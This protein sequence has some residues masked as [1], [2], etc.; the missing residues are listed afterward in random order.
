LAVRLPQEVLSDPVLLAA[1]DDGLSYERAAVDAHL[2]RAWCVRRAVSRSSLA[3]ARS[4][5]S[6][7]LP[8]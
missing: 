2:R 5:R 6:T 3:A 4:S 8:H 1:A 7:R